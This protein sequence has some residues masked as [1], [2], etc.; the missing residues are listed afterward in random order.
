[1][2]EI[3]KLICPDCGEAVAAT[4]QSRRLLHKIP[5]REFLQK[6]GKAAVAV[7][8]TPLLDFASPI[9]A[10][11]TGETAETMVKHLRDSLTETQKK[12]VLLPWNDPRRLHVENNWRVVPQQ[13]GE[14]YSREQQAIIQEILK[15]VTSE[16]G[17]EKILRAMQDDMG[18]LGNYSACLFSDGGEKLAFML[19]GR[20]QTLR[21]DGGT[22]KN[23]VFGGPIFYGH[24]VTF[25]ERPDHPG[26]VWWHQARLASKVF[27]ALDGK[28][29]KLALVLRDSPADNPTTIRLQ[30]KSGK[31]AGIPVSELSRDQKALVEEVIRSLL[32]PY[33]QSDVERAMAAVS[34]NGG[35][36]KLHLSFYQDGDLPDKDGIWDRWKLEGPS[37]V[38]YFRGSP[39]VHTWINIANGA[40]I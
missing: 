2:P 10:R 39:H 32:A 19:T 23:A 5:R 11:K 6:V 1:M 30:G 34:A 40:N 17:H 3:Q 38:W 25:Y 27:H 37:F 15:A 8:A 24:A 14:L 26:N 9:F 21:A 20:H 22:E 7:A 16:E 29:Q 12:A 31:F 18:G 33:R 13:L 4:N 35:V 28:Q 36:D